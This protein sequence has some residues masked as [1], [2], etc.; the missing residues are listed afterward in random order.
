MRRFECFDLYC[1][2]LQVIECV[3]REAFEVVG[4]EHTFMRL[5]FGY[6]ALGIQCWVFSVEYSVCRFTGLQV[7]QSSLRL[8]DCHFRS[9]V[10][11]LRISIKVD[12]QRSERERRREK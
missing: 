8:S 2:L 12:H 9:I 1:K 10:V 6:S 7:F 3:T 4:N 11:E 5:W